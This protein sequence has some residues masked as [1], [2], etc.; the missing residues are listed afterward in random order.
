MIGY[1]VCLSVNSFHRLILISQV[2]YIVDCPLYDVKRLCCLLLQRSF[3]HNRRP[4][5]VAVWRVCLICSIWS[6]IKN[7]TLT[8][9]SELQ[10]KDKL[11]S[12]FHFTN[13][14]IFKKYRDSLIQRCYDFVKV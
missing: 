7:N 3:N 8:L 13:K 6:L 12:K 10:C 1:N 5:L 11:T 2:G 9:T 14:D 4:K